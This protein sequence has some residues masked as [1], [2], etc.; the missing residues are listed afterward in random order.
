MRSE[1][2]ARYFNIPNSLSVIRIVCAPV[3]VVLLLSPDESWSIVAAS[4]FAAVCATDWLDGYLARRWSSVTTL[5][6]FLDPLADK[7]LITSALVMLVSLERIPAWAVAI[8][9]SREMAVTG[10]RSIAIETGVVIAASKLG[11]WKTMLQIISIVPLILYYPFFGVDFHAIGIELFAA[12]FI[13]TV[14]SGID[15]FIAFFRISR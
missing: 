4:V 5:G 2:Q 3:I 15:Y 7:I 6:K 8:M 9:I 12:A 10:L 1:T 13:L 14:W 11:K